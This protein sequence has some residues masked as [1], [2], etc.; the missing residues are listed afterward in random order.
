MS[1]RLAGDADGCDVIQIF[2]RSNRK[3]ASKPLSEDAVRRWHNACEASKIEP[4]AAHGSYLINLAASD[5]EVLGKSLRACGDEIDRCV[6]LDL[7]FLVLHPGSHLGFGINVG[8]ER[9]GSALRNL[10]D[11]I[12]SEARLRIALENV[13]GQG[14]NIGTRFEELRDLLGAIDRPDRLAVCFDTCHAFAA[15]YELRTQSGYAET[16][17]S[18]DRVIGLEWLALL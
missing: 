11:A 6:L 3:W 4:V 12:P 1:T 15:G 18:F 14:T 9:I 5:S 7:P 13:A 8:V 16:F 10:I 17:E 2:T